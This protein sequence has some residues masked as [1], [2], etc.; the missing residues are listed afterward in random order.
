M[1]I[2]VS[3]ITN[4]GLGCYPGSV[5]CQ[6]FGWLRERITTAIAGTVMRPIYIVILRSHFKVNAFVNANINIQ[7]LLGSVDW[8]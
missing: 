4:T 2:A 1:R 3:V 6:L 8:V 5:I 7:L